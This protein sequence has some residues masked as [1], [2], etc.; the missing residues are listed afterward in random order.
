MSTGFRWDAAEYARSSSAQQGWALELISKLGLREEESVLDVGCGDGK[1]T[2]EIARRVPRG[3]V[4]GLDSSADMIRLAHSSFP[5]SAHPNLAFQVGDA[6]ALA[7]DTAFDVVFSNAALHWVRE[8]RPV[9]RG[10]SRSLRPGGRA[11][12]QMGGRGNA[13]EIMNAAGGIIRA[14]AW[15]QWF[16]GF[17]SPWGFYGPEEYAPWCVEAG[18]TVRRL[19]LLPRRMVQKGAD[20]LAAWVRTTWMPYTERLP[21]ERREPFIREVVS[22]YL[23]AHP[24]DAEGNVAVGMVRL[25]VEAVRR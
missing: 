1:I 10:I 5:R 11:L 17:Q 8:H 9:L 19:E 12:L 4:V 2:A 20:G 14:P 16:E 6:G 21:E 23:Q 15:R 18:L 22:R 24:A 25:E 7:F 13:A 3:S